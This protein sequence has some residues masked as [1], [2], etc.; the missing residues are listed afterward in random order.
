MLLLAAPSVF[1]EPLDQYWHD[2]RSTQFSAPSAE[3]LDTAERLFVRLLRGERSPALRLAWERLGFELAGLR[4]RGVPLLVLR[5]SGANQEQREGRGLFAFSTR[6]TSATVLQAPHGFSE[7][8]TAQIAMRLLAEGDFRAAAWNTAAT[9]SPTHPQLR[10]ERFRLPPE[11]YITAFTRALMVALPDAR[12]VQ[13]HGFDPAEVYTPSVRN[14][15]LVVSGYGNTGSAATAR[16]GRCLKDRLESTVRI[17]PSEAKEMGATINR[18]GRLVSESGSQGFVHLAM[19]MEFRQEL[20]GDPELR[21]QLVGCLA[22]I[23]DEE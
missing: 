22:D 9:A 23:A 6:R 5:E 19:S 18:I 8:H 7:P 12:V 14:A 15:D 4:Y 2:A 10:P 21:H 20:L 17:F 1:A 13:L 11:D 3:E 16:R